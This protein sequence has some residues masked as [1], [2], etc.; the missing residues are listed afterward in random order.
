M[1]TTDQSRKS[2]LSILVVALILGVA[3]VVGFSTNSGNQSECEAQVGEYTSVR[4]DEGSGLS[5]NRT[6]SFKVVAGRG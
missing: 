6:T 1:N 5:R 4:W 2:I 3:I